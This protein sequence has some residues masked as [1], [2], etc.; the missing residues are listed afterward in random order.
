MER[1]RT[2]VEEA[3]RLGGEGALWPGFA[4]AAVPILLYDDR[5]AWLVGH[6]A[7]PEGYR[8]SGEVAGRPVYRSPVRPEM[9]ANTAAPVGGY[10]TALINLS[11]R[12]P[13]DEAALARLILHEAFHVFQQ[14]AL[15]AMP[16][17]DMEKL[18]VMAS[19]PE[20]DP[21]NNA[22]AIVENR[23]LARALAGEHEAVPA[24]LS[25]RRHRHR[26]LV[27]LDQSDVPVYEETVEWVEGTP[28]YVELRAGAPLDDL[29]GRLGTYNRGGRHAAYRRLYD[30]G[31]AQAVLLDRFAPGWQARLAESGGASLQELLRE[32]LNEPLPPVG[33]V[34]V[35]EGLA[36]VLEAEEEAEAQR[37]DRIAGLLRELEEGPGVLVEIA[38]PPAVKGGM[39]D[40]TNLLN[41]SPGRRL[42]TRFCG[43]VGPDGLRVTIHALCLEEWGETGR[44]FRLRVP[45]RPSIDQGAR[46][47][48]EGEGLDVDA[49]GGRVEDGAD[50]LRVQIQLPEL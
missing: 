50:G 23:L 17:M 24:F 3:H 35:A 30:T 12:P 43:A 21:G 48:V 13:S 42:H 37:Q 5:E 32:S 8:P 20:N 46:L 41:I 39:W 9:I 2:V 29:I 36:A 28:T 44:R 33:Q 26:R 47:R 10:L 6:P 34:V 27:R 4:L 45:A 15:P 1:I 11:D 14:V 18:Q 40:P 7:P 49:P 31:A 38:L 19:Y 25:M 16:R 22:M